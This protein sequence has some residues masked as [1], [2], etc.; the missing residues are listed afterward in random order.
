VSGE[1]TFA[2]RVWENEGGHLRRPG[3]TAPP[4]AGLA[5][6]RAGRIYDPVTGQDGIRVLVDRLWPRGVS[7]NRAEI[8]EW[9]RDVAPSTALRRWYAHDPQRY[10]EFRRRYRHELAAGEQAAAL[11]HLAELADGRTLTLLTASRDPAISE[12]AVLV[13]LLKQVAA[14]TQDRRS[15]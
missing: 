1:M 4:A 11:H 7:K 6:V 8:D 9:C 10:T 12:A 15:R 5:S 13:E 14:E 2:E 3:R